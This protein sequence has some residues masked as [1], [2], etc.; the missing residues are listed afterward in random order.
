MS[1][2]SRRRFALFLR[3]RIFNGHAVKPKR[4]IWIPLPLL[5]IL[6]FVLD[7]FVCVSVHAVSIVLLAFGKKRGKRTLQKQLPLA[8]SRNATLFFYTI[9]LRCDALWKCARNPGGG[10]GK[11][12]RCFD[13]LT[14]DSTSVENDFR[15][16]PRRLS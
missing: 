10:W 11:W 8:Q 16:H 4:N 12:Y 14:Y 3:I 6:A 2:L 5:F 9:E 7:V 15:G 13:G 1:W